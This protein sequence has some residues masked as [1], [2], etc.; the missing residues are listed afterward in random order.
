MLQ[1]DIELLLKQK[2][3]ERG[4]RDILMRLAEEQNDLRGIVNEMI[5]AISSMSSVIH[6]LNVVAD[7]MKNKIDSLAMREDDGRSTQGT[8]K[9]D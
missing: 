8:L 4:V 5:E 1:R 9:G 3:Y 6:T 2:G 7:G